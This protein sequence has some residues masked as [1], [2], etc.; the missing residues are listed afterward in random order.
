LLSILLKPFL[1]KFTGA[2]DWPEFHP[3]TELSLSIID[4]G[5]LFVLIEGKTALVI[6]GAADDL[7]IMKEFQAL[8]VDFE[9][10]ERPEFPSLAFYLSL[11]TRSGRHFR[12]EYFFSTESGD[13]MN[14]L[15][16][17]CVNKRFD[18]ILYGSAPE[19]VIRAEIPE[20][21]AR[22]LRALLTEAG[23]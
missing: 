19:F 21:Q 23:G 7:R 5:C 13:E 2:G 3:D 16:K 12:F 9:L 1:N 14:V 20:G 22:E 15:G 6:K 4:S 17:M 8:T 10:I 11:E 18:I